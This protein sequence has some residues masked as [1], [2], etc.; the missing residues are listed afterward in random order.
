M[1]NNLLSY[2]SRSHHSEEQKIY[3]HFIDR[4]QVEDAD[5]LIER[6]RLLFIVGSGYPDPEIVQA[7]KKI[8]AAKVTENDF[9]FIINRCCYILINRWH[10]MPNRR[11]AIYKIN[12][13]F[14]KIDINSSSTYVYSRRGS[15]S[16][17]LIQSFI[18]SEHYTILKRF[19]EVVG[20]PLE[21]Y[22]HQSNKQPLRRLIPR[23]PYLY[24]HCLV[25]DNTSYEHQQMIRNIKLK[26]QQKFELDLSQYV[27]HQW[28]RLQVAKVSL[29]TAKKI[30]VPVQNP[31]LLSNRE[32]FFA[33]EQFIGK[34]EGKNTYRDLAYRFVNQTQ[35]P[36][37]FKNFK[38]NLYEYLTPPS[39]SSSYTKRQFNDKL[40][41]QLQQIIPQSN[42][43]DFSDFLLLR[44]CSQILNFLIVESP[45]KPNHFVFLDLIA[46]L[47][48]TFAVGLFLK[49][50]LICRRVRPY[51]EKRFAILF[52]HYESST[53]EG[54]QWLVKVLENLNI[55]LTTNFG[56]VDLSFVC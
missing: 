1:N 40:Y 19:T 15:T 53:Q 38:N 10:T 30:T 18:K 55:A 22:P 43:E 33:I 21:I 54:V 24:H 6:F 52:N 49:I 17:R 3:D 23:Y 46:N 13:L 5:Q 42:E 48:P 26:K 8:I 36:Q 20:Q 51:L 4:V 28:R 31:T 29:E 47:G 25:S 50:A 56:S 16:S 11:Q 37:S 14:E 9:N 35:S 12:R 7:L 44:T 45:Q 41:Q 32:L 39:F 27:T 2:S 34:V